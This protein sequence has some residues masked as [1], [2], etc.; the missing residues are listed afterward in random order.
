[1]RMASLEQAVHLES[2]AGHETL[3]SF[4][5]QQEL[6]PRL[7]EPGQISLPGIFQ[8]RRAQAP[9]QPQADGGI[10]GEQVDGQP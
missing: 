6:P 9:L 7:H 2:G 8:C 1:M 4:R 10:P 3:Q 5:I